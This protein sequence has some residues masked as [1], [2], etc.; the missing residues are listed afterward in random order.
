VNVLRDKLPGE[1]QN[2]E[3]RYA[4][5]ESHLETTLAA[6]IKVLREQRGFTQAELAEATGTKQAAISRIE[7]AD[8]ANWKVSTL[9]K[10]GRALGVRVRISFETFGSLV[11]EKERFTR[12]DLER[13]DFE[14][15]PAFGSVA[16][17]KQG[18]NPRPPDLGLS[19]SIGH[20]PFVTTG[21]M[22]LC[23]QQEITSGTHVAFNAPLSK[24]VLGERRV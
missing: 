14:T 13:P 15:D 17:P 18:L 2:E 21:M 20:R 6:Q 3:Y 22:P 24:G 9:W 23:R 4:Y 5:A 1:F 7:S 10:I 19:R 12:A 11:E 16:S 8:P